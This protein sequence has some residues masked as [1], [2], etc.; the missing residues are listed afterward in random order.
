MFL[1][2]MVEKE[3]S[4]TLS[5]LDKHLSLGSGILR[6]TGLLVVD[7]L[8]NT[9]GVVLRPSPK[10]YTLSSKLSKYKQIYISKWESTGGR[11]YP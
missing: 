11:N 1:V 4:M 2:I 10:E 3:S 5:T 8:S 7:T 6:D 9:S